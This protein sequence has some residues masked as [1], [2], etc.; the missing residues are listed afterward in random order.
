MKTSG[1]NLR[2][3]LRDSTKTERSHEIIEVQIREEVLISDNPGFGQCRI[4][5]PPTI[6][7]KL[8]DAKM[9]FSISL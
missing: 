2:K 1:L 7:Y 4:A 8:I 5:T 3:N 9:F 6:L